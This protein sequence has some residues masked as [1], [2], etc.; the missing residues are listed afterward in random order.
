MDR[1]AP[2]A[3]L[4]LLV[5]RAELVVSCRQK[6]APTEEMAY[7]NAPYTAQV[8]LASAVGPNFCHNHKTVTPDYVMLSTTKHDGDHV[9]PV[10]LTASGSSARLCHWMCH[11]AWTAGGEKPH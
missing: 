3:K 5:I 8:S 6:D 4:S 10:D 11:M 2:C 1:Q 9:I 7:G